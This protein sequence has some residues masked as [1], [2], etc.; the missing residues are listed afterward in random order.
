MIVGPS[1]V[2]S[3][4]RA[5]RLVPELLRLV[6]R[7][8]VLA[9]PDCLA[10]VDELAELVRAVDAA[11]GDPASILTD[12]TPTVDTTTAARRLGLARRTVTGHC[13]T[14]RLTGWKVHGR[15]HVQLPQ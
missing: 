7:E 1:V 13:K 3:L 2:V 4:D 6:H 14:G 9:A 8:G 11:N 5:R 12:D 15:W 10:L